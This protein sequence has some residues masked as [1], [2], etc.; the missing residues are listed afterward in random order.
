MQE[1]V[2]LFGMLL[3][4]GVI[5]PAF[6]AFATWATVQLG[7][8]IKSK[9]HNDAVAGALDRLNQLA[10]HVVQEVQQTVVSALPN[11]ADKAALVAARD[12]AIT[13]LRSHLGSK[14]VAELMTVL[15]LKDD[16]ALTKL[17]VSHVESAVMSMKQANGPVTTV[18]TTQSDLM[19]GNPAQT[20]TVTQ[21]GT[22]PVTATITQGTP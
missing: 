21:P 17:L 8:W 20:V 10:F 11:K 18:T 14:G 2:E 22:P 9:V 4:K 19:T 6:A 1:Q 13:T 7:T 12:Q 5:A 16:N 3:I 15:G